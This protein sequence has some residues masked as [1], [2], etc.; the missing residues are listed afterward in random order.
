[1]VM[2][3]TGAQSTQNIHLIVGAMD[4][5]DTTAGSSSSRTVVGNGYTQYD[6]AYDNG[7]R[8]L[9]PYQGEERALVPYQEQEEEEDESWKQQKYYLE[10]RFDPSR[11]YEPAPRRP[12]PP[13][14]MPRLRN[15]LEDHRDLPAPGK[16]TDVARRLLKDLSE[17]ID[18]FET[19]YGMSREDPNMAQLE[20]K[21][22]LLIQTFNSI[23]IRYDNSTIRDPSSS[24]STHSNAAGYLFDQMF[25]HDYDTWDAFVARIFTWL[26]EY[27]AC[28]RGA[29]RH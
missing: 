17:F 19:C 24:S 10:D 16:A 25:D 1:M 12:D 4:I 2:V 14:S 18:K 7:E 26:N 13:V 15:W 29:S 27:R 3:A 11:S 28:R 6:E 21:G 8:A 22:Q 5:Q 20:H 9:V 23:M